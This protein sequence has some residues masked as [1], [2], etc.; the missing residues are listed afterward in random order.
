ME[1]EFVK[2]L[3]RP[4]LDC[5]F[6]SELT[7]PIKIV[8]IKSNKKRVYGNRNNG[9]AHRPKGAQGESRGMAQDA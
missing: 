8:T 6:V 5:I 7:I 3:L 9:S 4:R 1:E 2:G